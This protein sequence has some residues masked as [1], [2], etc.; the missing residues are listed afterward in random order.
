MTGNIN[1]QQNSFS[2]RAWT[3]EPADVYK[4]NG[5][6][7]HE[8]VNIQVSN[9][10]NIQVH[11]YQSHE[12]GKTDDPIPV[13]EAGHEAHFDVH[14]YRNSGVVGGKPYQKFSIGKDAWEKNHR[15]PTYLGHNEKAREQLFLDFLNGR[16]SAI[17]LPH[18]QKN[19]PTPGKR[20]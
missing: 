20:L 13:G 19:K 10:L 2:R 4:G 14:I 16:S 3:H 5:R 11:S 9:L 7:R 6:V 17:T 15:D 1:L 8:R 12:V 18:P